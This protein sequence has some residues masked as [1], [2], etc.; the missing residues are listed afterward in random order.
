MGLGV[1][2]RPSE[3][4]WMQVKGTVPWGWRARRRKAPVEDEGVGVGGVRE[5]VAAALGGGRARGGG[6]G[7]NIVT[8]SASS[9]ARGS[10]D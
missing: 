3:E 6:G 7:V 9:F 10:S 5:E 2:N 4:A 1:Q 8:T